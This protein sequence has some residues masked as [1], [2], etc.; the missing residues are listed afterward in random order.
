MKVLSVL[1]FISFA[2]TL[3][4]PVCVLIENHPSTISDLNFLYCHVCL[5]YNYKYV[6]FQVTN[7]FNH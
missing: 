5:K 6:T 4:H 7:P 1:D 3:F 2:S